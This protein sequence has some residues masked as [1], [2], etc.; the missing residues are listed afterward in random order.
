[1]EQT[2][3]DTRARGTMVSSHRGP[4]QGGGREKDL[5]RE[6]RGGGEG[7]G[8]RGAERGGERGCKREKERQTD[9]HRETDTDRQRQ[10]YS[11]DHHG[12]D[13]NRY[14]SSG[15]KWSVVIAARSREMGERRS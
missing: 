14:K 15:R 12:A 3:T 7:V 1:M 4:F 13:Y 8:E 9:R 5:K 11:R 10:R 6:G 2:T